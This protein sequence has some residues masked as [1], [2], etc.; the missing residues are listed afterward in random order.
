MEDQSE[1]Y[2]TYENY[3]DEEI[4]DIDIFYLEEI[5]L[6][7]DLIIV[8]CLPNHNNIIKKKEFIKI[9]ESEKKEEHRENKDTSSL[10][11]QVDNVTCNF[12]KE[13]LKRLDAVRNEIIACIVFIRCDN[14]KNQ[15]ISGYIDLSQ[16]LSNNEETQLLFTKKLYCQPKTSDLS[17]F[18]WSTMSCSH[19]NTKMFTVISDKKPC[20]MFMCNI[21]NFILYMNKKRCIDSGII[22]QS[23]ST[24]DYSQVVIY[25]H[26]INI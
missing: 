4:T 22:R 12:L 9:K 5:K 19:N 15:E 21:D 3:L 26:A 14:E 6:A 2:D 1:K 16:R 17:F 13:I 18:N 11:L 23:I 24:Q 20:L 10:P 25:E 8:D 7:R